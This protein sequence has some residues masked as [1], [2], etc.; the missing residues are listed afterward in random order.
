MI[1]LSAVDFKYIQICKA[2]YK[3]HIQTWKWQNIILFVDE[4]NL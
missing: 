2:C 3:Y 1:P 4:L